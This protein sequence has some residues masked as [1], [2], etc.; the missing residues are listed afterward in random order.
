MAVSL[1]SPLVHLFTC[2]HSCTTHDTVHSTQSA[3]HTSQHTLDTTYYT[4]QYT[5][6][7]TAHTSLHITYYTLHVT[8]YTLPTTHMINTAHYMVHATYNTKRTTCNML[9]ISL[10]TQL[11]T[12]STVPSTLLFVPHS[13][14]YILRGTCYILHTAF[15][16]VVWVLS[17]ISKVRQQLWSLVTV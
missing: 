1:R 6:Y 12:H 13:T 17:A 15:V 14:D 7:N 11:N 4:L 10:Y 2:L 9:Y 3:P 5:M 8:C 16:V